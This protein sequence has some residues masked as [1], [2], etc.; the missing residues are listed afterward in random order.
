V[1]N[2]IPLE[3]A[4]PADVLAPVIAAADQ[5]AEAQNITGKAVTPFLL[6]EIFNA[7]EGRS[8]EAN[9]ALVR[10]NARLGAHIAQA[11]VNTR[12]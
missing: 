10:H 4:I 6:S 8:L 9:I 5:K 7:T 11:L 3:A 2:P 12:Q 1:A